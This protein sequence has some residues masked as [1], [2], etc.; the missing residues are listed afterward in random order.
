MLYENY[1]HL[2]KTTPPFY[3]F[4]RK[5]NV[6]QENG[7]IDK[8][9][10]GN[11]YFKSDPKY[12]LNSAYE[13]YQNDL[14]VNHI[15]NMNASEVLI[16]GVGN[17][18]L[19]KSLSQITSKKIH[20]IEFI[21]LFTL[22]MNE[23]DLRGV[24]FNRFSSF[25]FMQ[26][27]FDLSSVQQ[28]L[29]KTSNFDIDFYF[30]PQ[31][32]R[33]FESE[34]KAFYGAFMKTI[35]T[36]KKLIHT[37]LAFEKRWVINSIKNFKHVS[38]TYNVLDVPKKSFNNSVA[39]IVSA[40]PSL[41]FELETLKS[42]LVQ[43]HAYIFAMGSANKALLNA[44]VHSD[45]IFSYDPSEKNINVL[46]LYK[47]MKPEIPLI[48]SSTIGNESLE[49][50][51]LSKS[52]HFILSQDSLYKHFTG[53]NDPK[54]IIRDSVSVAV[55]ALQ[56]ILKMGFRNVVFVGQNLAL[57]N[58]KVYDPG[59][60]HKHF[61]DGTL[62]SNCTTES[63]HGEHIESLDRLL[64]M[65]ENLELFINVNKGVTYINTTKQGAKIDGAP[66]MPMED[67]LPQLSKFEKNIDFAN[68]DGEHSVLE[69]D[70][71]KNVIKLL[72]RREQFLEEVKSNEDVLRSLANEL[73][74]GK[75]PNLMNYS[76]KLFSDLIK[77]DK[78]EYIKDFLAVMLR[79]YVSIFKAELFQINNK[80]ENR[81]KYVL[82]FK[83]YN[84]I[85]TYYRAYDKAMYKELISLKNGL[86][87]EVNL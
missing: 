39:F 80:E 17:A 15:E 53:K 48:F 78:N 19:L 34:V 72:K 70:V 84:T 36:K 44:G 86:E 29:V 27:K 14:I 5:F 16:I 32:K 67:L 11:F 22:M 69:K 54:L 55:V 75:I 31:Y 60:I 3:N 61:V 56:V 25:T 24:Q 63:V 21:E 43:N 35:E 4:Y 64:R 28:N 59:I 9:E 45:A 87:E 18:G 50:L 74:S 37:N 85:Y 57:L 52:Y 73:N 68:F 23:C 79:T 38:K 77:L 81:E 66:F 62:K 71:L 7:L 40:G 20:I 1:E 8:D 46:D 12:K 58:G 6:T 10:E 2:K 49:G 13:A 83:K 30:F 42:D 82:L 41:N 76:N 47:S 33:F 51:D 65:K 26:S